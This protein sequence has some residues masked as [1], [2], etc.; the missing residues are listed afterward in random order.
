MKSLIFTTVTAC[1][2]CSAID[3]RA[4]EA[5]AKPDGKAARFVIGLQMSAATN[6]DRYS[7]PGGFYTSISN[8][9]SNAGAGLFVRY[10]M[11]RHLALQTGADVKTYAHTYGEPQKHSIR[12]KWI[13]I[14]LMLQ[15]HVLKP[16]SKIRPYFGAGVV[17]R[18]YDNE[19]T[20]NGY[21]RTSSYG[22]SFLTISQGVTWQVN[23]KWQLNQSFQYIFNHNRSNLGMNL[24]IGYTIR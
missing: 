14:P 20:A 17:R 12:G 3:S 6:F 21:S 13:D 7:H 15:Y 5:V 18:F 22:V 4:Q 19:T 10:Y 9:F 11:G 23:D 24:G 16:G 8:T 2:M 1:L